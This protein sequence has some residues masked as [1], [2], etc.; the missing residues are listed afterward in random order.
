MVS[1]GAKGGTMKRVGFRFGI[2]LTAAAVG[3]VVVPTGQGGAQPAPPY[4]L[5]LGDSAVDWWWR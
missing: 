3:G 1:I 4:Y 2:F 5:A